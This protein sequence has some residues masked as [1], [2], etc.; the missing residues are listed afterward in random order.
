MYMNTEKSLGLTYA[1]IIFI[2]STYIISR[3]G[4][5]RKRGSI[6]N[7]KEHAYVKKLKDR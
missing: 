5:C 7:Y 2:L 6:A 1:Y 3:K 4:D